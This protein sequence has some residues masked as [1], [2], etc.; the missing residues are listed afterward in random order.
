MADL[1]VFLG[2]CAVF[3]GTLITIKP[4]DW[5]VITSRLGG[6]GLI[7]LGVVLLF[8]AWGINRLYYGW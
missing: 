1:L 7:A 2:T 8:I 6:L 4:P 3:F 5:Q